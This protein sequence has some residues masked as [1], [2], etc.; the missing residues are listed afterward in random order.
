MHCINVLK[1]ITTILT[2][3]RGFWWN[4]TKIALDISQKLNVFGH[5][6]EMRGTGIN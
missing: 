5:S 4:S 2:Q 1:Q 6:H 3:H